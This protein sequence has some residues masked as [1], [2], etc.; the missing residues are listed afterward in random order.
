M[1]HFT[2][3][4]K[5]T[6]KWWNVNHTGTYPPFHSSS[7]PVPKGPGRPSK[8]FDSTA[9][10]IFGSTIC[11]CFV[12]GTFGNIASFIYFRARKKGV[13]NT[14]YMLITVNDIL[15]SITVLPVGISFLSDR[16]PGKFFENEICCTVWWYIWWTTVR[17]SIFLV[18]CLCIARTL[19]LIKSLYSRNIS[20]L[21][22]SV[23][24]YLLLNT[25]QLVGFH[26]LASNPRYVYKTARPEMEVRHKVLPTTGFQLNLAG[27]NIVMVVPAFVVATS[28]ILSAVFLARRSRENKVRELQR[29]KRRATVTIL[30]FA[31]V[32]GVCNLPMVLDMII[33]THAFR[34]GNLKLHRDLML[35]DTQ[36]YY[37]NTTHTLL[38]AA[39]SAVNP[40][41]YFWRMTKLREYTI[42]AIRRNTGREY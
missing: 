4:Y 42:S 12:F 25:A 17:L 33:Q 18:I 13:S 29:I 22:A 1:D 31:L 28:C 21:I 20:F 9:D 40:V 5:S 14:T 41:L 11:L 26:K 34:T 6:P 3:D 8:N 38:I 10:I 23:G 16:Q 32:Y 2:V 35:F 39:N 24:V 15:I 37:H 27:R 36:W 30:L 19:A 7:L